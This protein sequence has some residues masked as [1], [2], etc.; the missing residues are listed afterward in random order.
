MSVAYRVETEVLRESRRKLFGIFKRKEN[1][2]S[3]TGIIIHEGETIELY[4]NE[5]V[6]VGVAT[7][8]DGVLEVKP[9]GDVL[10]D[11]GN[12]I[13][14]KASMKVIDNTG[15]EKEIWVGSIKTSDNLV[16]IKSSDSK[17]KV[18]LK[19]LRQVA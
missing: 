19:R 3:P 7:L 15:Q 16:I 17:K 9:E 18:H 8:K 6:K 14:F 12:M 5:A 1:V 10:V 11:F 13:D 2:V 4:D